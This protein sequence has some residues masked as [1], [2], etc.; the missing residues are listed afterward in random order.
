M[1]VVLLVAALLAAPAAPDSAAARVEPDTLA[2]VSRL[3]RVLRLPELVVKGE[4]FRDAFS[5]ES[6]HPI[7]REVVR[8]LPIDRVSELFALQPGVVARGEELHVRGGRTGESRMTLA[9]IGLDDPVRG[10]SMELPLLALSDADLASGGIDADLGGALAGILRLRTLDPGERWN[11]V[12]EWHTDGRQFTHYDRAGARIGGPLGSTGA[13]LMATFEGTLDDTNLPNLRTSERDHVLGGSFGWRADNRMLGH[14]KLATAPAG[15]RWTLELAGNR[16]LERPYDPAWFLNGFTTPCLDPDTC[17]RGPGFSLIPQPGFTRYVAADHHVV[18]DDRRAMGAL[19]WE[20]L[21]ERR[22]FVV[23]LGW[24]GGRSVTSIDGTENTAYLDPANFPAYG[25]YDSAD[26]DP[27]HVYVGDEPWYHKTSSNRWTLRA[28]DQ[29]TTTRGDV[30]KFGAGTTYDEVALRDMDYS[31]PGFGLDSVRAYHAFAPGG[32]AYGHV[33]WVLG[34][35]VANGGLRAEYF[36]AGPQAQSQSFPGGG[37][38]T[39]SLSPR[40]GVA[41]PVSVRDVFSMSYVRVQQ[42]PDRDYLYDN[43]VDISNREPIG[44]PSLVPA[45]EISYQA[46]VKHVFDER[47]AMQGA[48]FYRDVFGL[49]GAINRQPRLASPQLHYENSDDANASGVEWTLLWSGRPGNFAEVHYTYLDA[50]GTQSREEGVPY[51]PKLTARPQALGPHPL[52]WDRRHS[53]NAGLHFERPRVGSI[54]W[55]TSVGSGLPWS[56]RVLRQLEVDLDA[57][58]SRR[59]G[60]SENTDAALRWFVPGPVRGLTLG[61][62]VRNVFDS[63]TDLSATTDGYPNL[64][65]NTL[66][67]D[68]GAYRTETGLPG[69]AYYNDR[70]GDGQPGWI[71][72]HDARLLGPPRA[73]RMSLAMTW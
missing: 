44:N 66:Y 31:T 35:M 65:I 40:L 68:Y 14:L 52:D 63:R 3:A 19:M 36:T 58:N 18:T 2:R 39:W 24:L 50:R 11:G 23:T 61:L 69:G 43:R 49:I 29:R 20:S 25:L 28:D 73:M 62:D 32:W 15:S 17:V 48:V 72:V 27:F 45:T 64:T 55:T 67:D 10:S 54:A 70:N 38:G 57:E 47:W 37:S 34:G 13:R 16:R 56:P 8:T 21:G 41:Y 42:N 1:I 33:R 26:N 59:F 5:S 46:A 22:R 51:G 9:G 4:R 7:P 53:F 6:V 30:I 71:P 12:V 60:W